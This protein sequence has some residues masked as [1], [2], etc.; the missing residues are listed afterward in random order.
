MNANVRGLRPE[1]T[2][3]MIDLVVRAYAEYPERRID[4][5]KVARAIAADPGYAPEFN[6]VVEVDG[7]LAGRLFIHD[8]SMSFDGGVL[9]VGAI[10]GVCVDPAY[11]RKG[12]CNLLLSDATVFMESHGFDV[13]L[14]FG[15]P[16]V[17]GP[18]GWQTLVTS[19]MATNLPLPAV[20]DVSVRRADLGRDGDMVRSLYQQFNSSLTGPFVRSPDY[21]NRWIGNRLKEQDSL[22]IWIV[23]R[24]TEPVGYFVD[25]AE[26]VGMVA[27]M[28]WSRQ[29]AEALPGM[30]S[31]IAQQSGGARLHF[32]FYLPELRDAVLYG[33]NVLALADLRRQGYD[34]QI[35]AH[36]SGLFKLINLKGESLSDVHDTAALLRLFRQRNYV[37]WGMDSF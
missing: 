13:S 8:R 22:R 18:S 30:L 28:A 26:A 23:Y 25:R 17:Y 29:N 15:E 21:W 36:Y 34:L 32:P 10:G 6:R 9:R 33:P 4:A 27:E 3:F 19:A 1:E 5:D 31:A 35:A 11:R 14:L 2:A 20:A 7:R 12:F 37:F 16:S 24:K